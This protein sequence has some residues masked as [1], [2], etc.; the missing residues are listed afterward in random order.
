MVYRLKPPCTRRAVQQQLTG[1]DGQSRAHRHRTVAKSGY[2]LQR[3]VASGLSTTHCCRATR[4]QSF[5][6]SLLG[7]CA[8]SL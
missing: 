3:Q 6:T 8:P 5:V 2:A 1:S 4:I 7:W